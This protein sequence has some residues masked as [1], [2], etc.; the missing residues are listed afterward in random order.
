MFLDK[1]NDNVYLGFLPETENEL[2]SLT[3]RFEI[4]LDVRVAP[5]KRARPR[6]SVLH[7]LQLAI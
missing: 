1:L 6:G 5:S 7:G 2:C 4:C 3:T